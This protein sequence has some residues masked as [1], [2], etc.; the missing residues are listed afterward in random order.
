M[1]IN[2]VIR[3]GRLEKHLTQE[4][5]AGYLGVSAPAVNK[6]EKGTSYPDITLLPAIARLLDT[7]LNTL[8]SFQ[9][10]LSEK[11]VAV[12]VNHLSELSESENFETVFE[13]AM[14]KIKQF[15]TCG[16]LIF[17]TAACLDG[18]LMFQGGGRKA[19]DKD[20]PLG[21]TDETAF[22][23]CG[24]VEA[25]YVRASKCGDSAVQ[26]QAKAMLVSK[27]T[28]RK[29]YQRAQELLDSLPD[30][31]FFDKKQMKINLLTEQGKLKAAAQMAEEKLLEVTNEVHGVLMS[32]MELAI[33]EERTED[34][35]YIAET[36]KK[37]AEVFDLWE[38][39]T[40]VAHLQLYTATKARVKSLKILVPM[41]KSLTKPWRLNESPLYR[42]M[43]TKEVYKAFGPKLKKS[44]IDAI[45]TDEDMA[46]LREDDKIQ[47]LLREDIA[48]KN[49]K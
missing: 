24:A 37:A 34:A 2:E 23:F 46:F 1:K 30:E 6:W 14:E 36:D 12:F 27:Y 39:N 11:E 25:L 49:E 42:H 9:E 41:L 20:M 47:D 35:E 17:N 16:L 8:L 4:E 10:D 43:K 29:D 44:L 22:D 48:G 18:L 33:L 28:A 3:K 38:Y 31:N 19:P 5:M 13:T 45:K 7:D 32:L 15:P 21:A 26:N 40:Y